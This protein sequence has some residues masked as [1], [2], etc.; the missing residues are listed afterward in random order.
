MPTNCSSD[1]GSQP[2]AVGLQVLAHESEQHQRVPPRAT[3]SSSSVGDLLGG[4]QERRR[5]APGWLAPRT[6]LRSAVRG[7][8]GR[9]APARRGAARRRRSAAACSAS[10]ASTTNGGGPR[11]RVV[12]LG[13]PASASRIR[14]G[15]TAI[16]TAI[17]S[18]IRAGAARRPRRPCSRRSAAPADRL[19]ELRPPV[20]RVERLLG[21]GEQQRCACRGRRGRSCPRR[22]PRPRAIS[23]VLDARRRARAAAGSDDGDDGRAALVGGHRGGT[24]SHPPEC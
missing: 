19:V 12:G 7:D 21:G 4:Q 15:R 9:D 6:R 8:L 5:A 16:I 10:L 22:C 23:R 1:D 2:G 17:V 20:G 3:P 13:A 14:C 24:G 11:L 18:C